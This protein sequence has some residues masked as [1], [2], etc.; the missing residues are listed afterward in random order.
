M[1]C[2]GSRSRPVLMSA[3][4]PVKIMG[5]R[6]TPG[7]LTSGY[8]SSVPS[9]RK[10]SYAHLDDMLSP[11]LLLWVQNG[12]HGRLQ[13]DSNSL[14]KAQQLVS[15]VPTN[16]QRLGLFI[17][18]CSAA[19]RVGLVCTSKWGVVAKGARG[20]LASTTA[21]AESASLGQWRK[22]LRPPAPDSVSPTSTMS[23]PVRAGQLTEAP[24]GSNI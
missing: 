21:S 17:I 18:A 1:P 19:R 7:P 15:G 24:C 6:L 16:R 22:S 3:M 13:P 9:T 5:G 8:A 20:C 11:R 14:F 2:R 4:T 23:H 12:R 10:Q